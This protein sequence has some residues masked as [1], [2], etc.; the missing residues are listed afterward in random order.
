M[1]SRP[2]TEITFKTLVLTD[3]PTVQADP[4]LLSR[5]IDN[6]LNNAFKY[7][8]TDGTI[9][10]LA[11]RHGELLHISIRDDG[12]GIPPE[13]QQK[14]FDNFFQVTDAKGVP[15]RKGTGLG[16]AFCR[17]AVEAHG[18]KI[19][20]VSTPGQGSTFIFTLPLAN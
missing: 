17:L 14:I 3:L 20:V 7:T 4:R 16:L 6:L 18:G 10:L 2:N 13:Y 8:N 15:I 19:W 1:R 11:V 9:E 12:Q 5:V